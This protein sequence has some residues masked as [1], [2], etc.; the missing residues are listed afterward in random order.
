MQKITIYIKTGSPRCDEAMQYF[1][2]KGMGIAVV[3]V[4]ENQSALK[5]MIDKSGQMEVPVIVIDEDDREEVMIG[6]NRER[7]EEYISF[8]PER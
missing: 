7:L 5:A 2:E 8:D 6:F 3:N 1:R 4:S